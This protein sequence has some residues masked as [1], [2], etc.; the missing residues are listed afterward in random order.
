MRMGSQTT[1]T[2]F[3]AA[4]PLPASPTLPHEGGG[5]PLTEALASEVVGAG[6]SD[7]LAVALMFG[8]GASTSS[9]PPRRGRDREGGRPHDEAP[10]RILTGLPAGRLAARATH[11][12]D[13][14]IA[15]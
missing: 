9:P 12:D 7:L 3:D 5:N 8:S 15:R 2:A 11:V 10:A 1:A 13:G 14:S 6:A 4:A